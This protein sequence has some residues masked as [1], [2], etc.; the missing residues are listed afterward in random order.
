MLEQI[1]DT[2]LSGPCKI[3]TIWYRVKR[4]FCDAANTLWSHKIGKM[5][6]QTKRDINEEINS[7]LLGKGSNNRKATGEVNTM[8]EFKVSDQEYEKHSEDH[9]PIN[10]WKMMTKDA[11]V[12]LFRGDRVNIG[13]VKDDTVNTGKPGRGGN[14]YSQF[15]NSQDNLLRLTKTEGYKNDAAYMKQVDNF[16]SVNG[17][18]P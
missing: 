4:P 17:N 12:A 1:E 7:L 18:A 6:S 3:T 9:F 8:R 5:T 10:V 16:I 14:M 15:K 13:F 2:L 11:H